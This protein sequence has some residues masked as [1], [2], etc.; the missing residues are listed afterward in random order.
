M[1]WA[2]AIF[3]VDIPYIDNYC[4]TIAASWEPHGCLLFE[5]ISVYG[6]VYR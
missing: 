4:N 6:K 1:Y 5:L 3:C 2:N